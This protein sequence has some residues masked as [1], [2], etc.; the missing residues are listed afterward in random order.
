MAGIAGK[1]IP[2]V[3]YARVSTESQ[4]DDELPITA[5]LD[6][7]RRFALNRGYEIVEEFIDAGITGRTENRPE[8]TRLRKIIS[9]GKAE[10][11]AVIV[12]RSNRFARSSRIAQG[13][14]F[15]LEQKNIRLFSVTEPEMNGSI[16]V[17]MNGILDAFNEFYSAQLGEDT[18][19]GM[20]AA[21]K[22]GYATGG[23]T[24]Y[25]LKRVPIILDSGAVKKKFEP[26]PS[27]APIVRRIYKMYADGSGLHQIARLLNVDGVKTKKGKD[28][29]LSSVHHILFKNRE[30]YLGHIIFNRTKTIVKKRIAYKAPDEWIITENAHE[31][32]ITPEMAEAVDRRHGMTQKPQ[33]QNI[34]GKSLLNGLIYCG[35]CG[36]RFVGSCAH[37]GKPENNIRRWY[38]GCTAKKHAMKVDR[39]DLCTNI[40]VRQ[41]VVEEAVLKEIQK[42]FCDP[43]VLKTMIEE[44]ESELNQGQTDKELRARLLQTEKNDLE[45]RRNNLLDAVEQGTLPLPDVA[46]RIL[47]VKNRLKEIELLLDGYDAKVPTSPL[48]V[49]DLN[50]IAEK[51][52]SLLNDPERRRE[53]YLAFVER[54][55][56][57]PEKLKIKFR[58]PKQPDGGKNGEGNSS[59]VDHRGVLF[60]D[61]FTEFRRDL[62]E[63][64]RAPLEDG[65]V[66]VSR[67]A[68]TVTYPSRVLL[69]LAA[70][71]CACGHLG[72]PVEKCVC[73]SAE[74]DRYR[75]KLSGPILDRIDL[76]ISVPRLLPEELLSFSADAESSA[77]IRARVCRARAVQQERWAPYG[78][79]CNAELPERIV[80]RHLTLLPEVR[81]FLAGM[82]GKL[83]LSGRGISR[84]LKVA[85]TIADLADEPRL[86]VPHLAEALMYRRGTAGE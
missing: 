66:V 53:V 82:A 47:K 59:T 76:Q 3:A 27:E 38:Y 18:F 7:V 70:N 44:A 42:S 58:V 60:L 49:L 6:E 85:R 73:S 65:Q 16:G 52:S 30:Y 45:K 50:K 72:D 43:N 23:V 75:R 48:D 57:Y 28:W 81:D 26:H 37:S 29:E 21:A 68:G 2:A 64:L 22:A 79:S 63:S 19:R 33:F 40:Y 84:V 17:L 55:D 80:R 61:E 10:F 24:P 54:I 69:A 46:E 39:S 74:L 15:L 8:F 35:K 71:P 14:R 4:A 56:V 34:H 5:Q 36:R 62:T 13:F 9:S 77:A 41:E 83:R 31:A 78:F 20:I 1:L 32:I 51:V 25:G 12:W 67:A 86:Q 11:Q